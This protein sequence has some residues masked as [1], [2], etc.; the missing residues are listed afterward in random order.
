MD[1]GPGDESTTN[2]L[3]CPTC[4]AVQEWSDTCRRCKSD[5][6][7]LREVEE[8]YQSNRR[9]CLR[10]LQAGDA[11]A[12]LGSAHRCYSLRTDE[13][14]RKLLALSS[15]LSGDWATADALARELLEEEE[16]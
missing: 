12:A 7:L 6:R 2:T 8:A 5:L 11:R 4:R 3:I 10:E 13:E 14:S 1:G 16:A 9:A 15:L